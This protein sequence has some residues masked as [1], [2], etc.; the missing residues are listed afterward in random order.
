MNTKHTP[1]PWA[2]EILQGGD[3]VVALVYGSDNT[4]SPLCIA[5]VN[6]CPQAGEALANARLIASAPNLLRTCQ[7]LVTW[8]SSIRG[9]DEQLVIDHGFEDGFNLTEAETVI[10]QATLQQ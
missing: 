10:Q 3:D 9:E 8:L 1:G 2:L 7:K 4:R 5:D 6:E